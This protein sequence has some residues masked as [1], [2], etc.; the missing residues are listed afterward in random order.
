MRVGGSGLQRGGLG[1]QGPCES[2]LTTG[3]TQTWTWVRNPRPVEEIPSSADLLI[4]L[5]THSFTHPFIHLFTHTCTHS[6]THPFIHSHSFT[7]PLIRSLTYMTNWNLSVWPGLSRARPQVGDC[8]E[9][10]IGPD[11]VHRGHARAE[12]WSWC[13][14]NS[15]EGESTLCCAG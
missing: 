12:R 4:H 8:R 13:C 7:H 2:G 1:A 15:V 6:F 5:F 3:H 10:L 9:T 14:G 11:A